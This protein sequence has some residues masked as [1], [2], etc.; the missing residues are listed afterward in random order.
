MDL[1]NSLQALSQMLGGSFEEPRGEA[2]LDDAVRSFLGLAAAPRPRAAIRRVDAGQHRTAQEG[3]R[4]ATFGQHYMSEKSP[5]A[6]APKKAPSKDIWDADEVPVNG[7][8]A[9]NDPRKRPEYEILYK[10]A[11]TAEDMFIGLS[12]RDPSS[13]SCE[14]LVVRITLPGTTGKQIELDV[15]P[16]FLDLRTPVYRLGLHLPHPVDDKSG[17]AKWDADAGVLAVTLRLNREYDF[18]RQ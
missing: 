7:Y 13:G 5:R 6:A 17:N 9:D 18:L 14:D 16:Q 15:L 2:E 4:A 11:V 1:G 10:Q 12:G 3:A 8:G